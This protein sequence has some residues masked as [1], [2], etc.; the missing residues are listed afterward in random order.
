MTFGERPNAMLSSTIVSPNSSVRQVPDIRAQ[1][2]RLWQAQPE[3]AR[4]WLTTVDAKRA[5]RVSAGGVR[6]LVRRGHLPYER[7]R[8]GQFLFREDDV[9]ALVKKRAVATLVTVRPS[10]RRRRTTGPRQLAMF[11][12]QLRILPRLSPPLNAARSRSARAR[13]RSEIRSRRV[14]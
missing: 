5:L 1:Y 11:G 7:T 13:D 12:A 9:L 6:D 4:L 10:R 14:P 8:S 3:P 2:D